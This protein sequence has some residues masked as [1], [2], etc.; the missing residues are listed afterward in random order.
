MLSLFLSMI[1]IPMG[2]ESLYRTSIAGINY[3]RGHKYKHAVLAGRTLAG[4]YGFAGFSVNKST[5][6]GLTSSVFRLTIH[7]EERA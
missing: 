5:G 7:S 4:I 6:I 3:S 1:M 2:M